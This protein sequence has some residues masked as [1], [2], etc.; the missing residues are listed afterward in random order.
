[1]FLLGGMYLVPLD[2]VISE[3]KQ[4]AYD[5]SK[6]ME[7]DWDGHK[8]FVIGA[9]RT[10]SSGNS[11]WVDARELY[12]VR[13]IEMDNDLRLDARMSKHQNLGNGWSETY[14]DIY[15]N[16]KLIQ[17]E[18]YA[19]LKTTP[20]VED[21]VFDVKDLKKGRWFEKTN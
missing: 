3:F 7:T 14:V 4:K 13:Q 12:V 9:D 1:M 2:T 20:P 18:S 8:V 15:G 17:T 5:L 6:T 10:D 19:N 21:A 16:G 11:L